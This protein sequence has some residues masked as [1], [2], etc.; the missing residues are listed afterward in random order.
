MVTQAVSY[1]DWGYRSGGGDRAGVVIER[2]Y[3]ITR[4]SRVKMLSYGSPAVIP[5]GLVKAR[6]SKAKEVPTKKRT[7]KKR[8][9]RK[10]PAKKAPTAPQ[11]ATGE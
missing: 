4:L 5:A 7:A 10:A 6:G 11:A 9:I 1:P 2:C 3:G 8:S